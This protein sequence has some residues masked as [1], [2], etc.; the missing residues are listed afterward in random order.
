MKNKLLLII[1]AICLCFPKLNFGQV[2]P[3]LGVVSQFV[4]F[5][6]NGAI[7]HTGLGINSHI[8]GDVGSQ[9]GGNSGFGNVDGVMR[10]GDGVT[11]AAVADLN[12]M[13][14]DLSTQGPP[15]PHVALLGGETLPPGIYSIPVPAT[16][17]LGGI[18][19]LDG[20]GDPNAYFLFQLGFDFSTGPASE[21]QL[22]NGA[23]ACNVFWLVEGAVN[24]ATGTK[25]RGNIIANNAAINIATGVLLEGRALSTTGA[26]AVNT[27]LVATM[28]IGCGSPLLTGPVGPNLASA[29]CY[30]VFSADGPVTDDFASFLTGDVGTNLGSTL[31]YD[32]LKVVGA[33]HPIPD[34]STNACAVDIGPAYNYLNLLPNDIQLL[35][36]ADFG[37]SLVLTPHTY[38]MNSAVTFTDT[39][40]LNAEGNPAAVFVI[41]VNAAFSTGTYSAVV[42]QNGAQAKNVFWK[43]DG[44]VTI[45][46]YSVFKGTIV[47]AGA[48]T[49]KTGVNIE[50]RVLT[51]VGAIN[52]FATTVI[53]PAGTCGAI[54]LPPIIITEPMNQNV[55]S[56]NSVSFSVTATGTALTYQWRKGIVNLI[57]GGNISGATTAT[58][59]INPATALDAAANYNVIVS[60]SVPPNDTS[61]NVSLTINSGT[62]ITSEPM[63]QTAC[64]GDSVGFSVT[65]TGGSLTY[66]WRKGIVNL[67]NGGSISGAT[68]SV[69]IINPVSI[70]DAALN[71][72]VIVSGACG[73]DTSINVSLTVNPTPIANAGSNSP[74]CLGDSI[75]LTSSTVAGATYSWTSSTGYLSSSQ[76]PV[77]APAL[78]SDAGTYSLTL[79]AGG[80]TSA[81]STTIVVVNICAV[82]LSVVKTVSNTTP[83]IGN[84][85]VFTIV[86]TNNGSATATGVE[87][88]EVLQSGYTYVSSAATAGS[89]NASTGVWTIGSISSGASQTLTITVNVIAN[90]NYVN[91]VVVYGNEIDGNLANNNS[92]VET[93]PTDFNI[94]EGFSPNDDGTND[95]FVI[96]GINNFP[97]NTFVIFNRWGDKVFEAKNYQNTWGGKC[98]KGLRIGGDDLP[99]GTYFYV[100]DLGDGSD[101]FKGTIYL[102]K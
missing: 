28:P 69:L 67:I 57:D 82:D 63:N 11:G 29:A 37:Y 17:S 54:G 42:L 39:L 79:T 59:T 65:A 41:Q 81:P 73:N 36:P 12:A 8:T 33:I 80:C 26:I 49:L 53:V 32:P 58:L 85:I 94:P 2:P 20:L 19:V 1:T 51:S 78:L 9:I 22:V 31:G 5:S 76:N 30:A 64:V 70:L 38:V 47:S 13:Y 96:R 18:L 87:V 97:E 92:S 55:C 71:Y 89:Y 74:V 44:A 35:Y 48:I 88:N 43:I 46:D 15:T 23:K 72:N 56:G 75:M 7:T 4:I 6:S 10:A 77:I 40:F 86:V 21:I 14:L 99:I 45:N 27:G 84:T 62:V 90:G 68:S 98:S 91:T 24:I 100:L 93:F 102:N 83:I 25:M 60:G 16:P 95:L 52:T 61:I 66:Q 3:A 34:G 50:G 101:I